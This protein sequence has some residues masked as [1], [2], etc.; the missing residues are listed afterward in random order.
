MKVGVHQPGLEQVCTDPVDT[1]YRLSGEQRQRGGMRGS[2][3]SNVVMLYMHHCVQQQAHQHRLAMFVPLFLRGEEGTSLMRHA[4]I[5]P[6]QQT[7]HCPHGLWH[8]YLTC[9]APP[10][11]HVHSSGLHKVQD[12]SCMDSQDPSRG[13]EGG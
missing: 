13:E 12:P 1:A 9:S 8:K 2:A 5:K 7:R 6:Q 4:H 11:L 10:L 3:V